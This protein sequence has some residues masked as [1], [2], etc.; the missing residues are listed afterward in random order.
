MD[1]NVDC[2]GLAKGVTLRSELAIN[3]IDLSEA[4]ILLVSSRIRVNK[5]S[6]YFQNLSTCRHI[7]SPTTEFLNFYFES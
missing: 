7:L 3:F 2:I 5:L 4:E 6:F 1:I